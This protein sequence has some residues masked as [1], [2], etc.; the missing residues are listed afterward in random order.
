MIDPQ[1]HDDRPTVAVRTLRQFAALWI[2]ILG[3]L[4]AWHGLVKGRP[5]LGVLLSVLAVS[6]GIVGLIRPE[7]VRPIYSG[8]M[9]LTYPIGRVVSLVLLAALFYGVFTPLGLLFRLVGRDALGIRRRDQQSYWTPK[10][11]IVDIRSYMR[12]S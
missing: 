6:I 5:F 12:Q 9:A 10:P 7:K 1:L 4:G 3:A 8:L 11:D 2:V